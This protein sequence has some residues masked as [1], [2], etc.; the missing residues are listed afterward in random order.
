MQATTKGQSM[1]WEIYEGSIIQRLPR[2]AQPVALI[3][4]NLKAFAGA[5][6]DAVI[7]PAG[8][9]DG[10]TTIHNDSFID[11]PRF[12]NAYARA[13]V[14]GGFD[15]GIP[16]RVH[17]ALWCSRIAQKLEGDFVEL[18]TGR[19]FMMSAVLADYTNWASSNRSLHLFD[20]FS[21]SFTG[22]DGVQSS[23][24]EPSPFYAR[25]VDEV[26]SNFSEWS[27]VVLHQGDLFE[28]LPKGRLGKVAF[29]HV[30]LNYYK[31]EVFGIRTIWPL[32]PKGGVI[33]LDDYAYNG[34]EQ[35]YAAINELAE[36]LH[37]DV[38][39]TPTGQGIIIK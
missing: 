7:R 23:D 34:Y 6:K 36:E 2:I 13:V 10:I 1:N 26:R 31:P 15:Y 19:G 3:A 25:S 9:V 8:T 20:T 21:S 14:A 16:Y 38:L 39:S 5:D 35:Q 32:I 27:R 22:K 17:Q 12:K 18:G 33:L 28:T 4:R 37:F 11:T 29:L 24:D 30:D